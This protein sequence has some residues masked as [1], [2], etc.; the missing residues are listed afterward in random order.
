M[1]ISIKKHAI[2]VEV[3][4]AVPYQPLVRVGKRQHFYL[5]LFNC[6]GSAQWCDAQTFLQPSLPLWCSQW[7]GSECLVPWSAPSRDWGCSSLCVCTQCS[8][9]VGKQH[10]QHMAW[11]SAAIQT[12]PKVQP[13]PSMLLGLKLWRIPTWVK[14]D[15]ISAALSCS[16]SSSRDAERGPSSGQALGGLMP[17][18]TQPTLADQGRCPHWGSVLALWVNWD[19][20]WKSYQ[21]LFV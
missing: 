1:N 6:C 12:W 10:C 9:Q 7:G 14:E 5:C 20:I 18:P 17:G 8:E 2:F 21:R 16:C 19:G 15:G 11:P 13:D 3:K 4:P